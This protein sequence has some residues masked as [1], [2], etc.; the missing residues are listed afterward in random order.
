MLQYV[1]HTADVR[2]RSSYHVH[3]E[4]AREVHT[5]LA[6]RVIRSKVKQVAEG[7]SIYAFKKILYSA[8]LQAASEVQ[9]ACSAAFM[10][11]V[12]S[13]LRKLLMHVS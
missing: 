5:A 1:L 12:S 3:T 9:D 11:A 8:I 10:P 13:G 4:A 7:K 2:R 6:N